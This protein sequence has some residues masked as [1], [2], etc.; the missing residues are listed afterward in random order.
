MVRGNH[1]SSLKALS[2]SYFACPPFS[3]TTGWE[4]ER[5]S[6]TILALNSVFCFQPAEV[7]PPESGVRRLVGK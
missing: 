2:Y 4:A 5:Y 1:L 3:S 7:L 6:K